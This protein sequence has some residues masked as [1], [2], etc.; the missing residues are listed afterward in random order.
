MEG[1]SRGSER[2]SGDGMTEIKVG[3]RVKVEYE[4]VVEYVYYGSGE[5]NIRVNDDDLM[6]ADPKYITK[7]SPPEPPVGSVVVVRSQAV[8]A[9]FQI[10]A[11]KRLPAG[12]FTR[13]NEPVTWEVVSQ[14]DIIA[15][16]EPEAS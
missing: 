1:V 7:L 3:D 12:W 5:C 16:H 13:R 8:S 6:V 14:M 10:L 9:E 4:G 15:I 11:Y 2:G